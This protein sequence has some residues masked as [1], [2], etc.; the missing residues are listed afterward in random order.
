MA[1]GKAAQGAEGETTPTLSLRSATFSFGSEVIL[2]DINLDVQKSEILVLVG[3]SGQGKTTLLKGLAGLTTPTSGQ[4]LI[5]GLNFHSLSFKERQRLLLKMGILFQKN[6][7]FDSMSVGDNVAFPLRE[8][9]IS[10]GLKFSEI[11][12][13]EKVDHYLDAVGLLSAKKLA[14]SEIS[15]GMQKRLG[16]ARA[17]AL[18]PEIIFYDDPTAGLDP[19]TSRKIIDLIKSLQN[20]SHSTNV[21]VT[22]D[23]NRAEQVSDQMVLVTEKTIIQTGTPQETWASKDPRV[24]FFIRGQIH[25]SEGEEVGP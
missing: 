11:E 21:I 24:Y 3:P 17:L 2:Q 25:P 9:Q 22:N 12:I 13:Q 19:I 20:E 6:A 18:K 8:S 10:L 23:M 16:I 5:E 1:L 15:G 4:L 14:P 7:L